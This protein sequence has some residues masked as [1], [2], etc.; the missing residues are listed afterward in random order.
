MA[1]TDVI[2]LP[3]TLQTRNLTLATI[4]FALTFWAWN[5]IGPLAIR[6][7]EQ[8]SLTTSQKSLLIATPVLVG[9]ARAHSRGRTHR[10][11]RR[12]ADVHGSLAGDHRAGAARGGGPEPSGRTRC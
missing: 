6:Y 10:P 1:A 5:L 12:A 9:V 7:S 11:V 3:K 2:A 4:A 8:L